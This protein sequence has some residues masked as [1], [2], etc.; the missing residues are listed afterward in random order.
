MADRP[1]LEARNLRTYFRT[2]EGIARAVDGVS[3]TLARGETLGLVGESGC[4][5]SVTALT[6]MQLVP[7]PA[8][9]LAGGEIVLDGDNLVLFTPRQKREM[10]GKRMAMVFQDPMTALNPVF[11]IGSQIVETIRQHRKATRHEARR[12]AIEML[13]RVGIPLPEQRFG[14]YS[15]QLSGGMQQRAMIA[16]ALCCQPDILIA[17]EPTTALDV[18]IQAQ[19]LDLLRALQKEFGM[20]IL[21]ITHNLGVVAEMAHRVSVMYA[22]KI[23]ES[24]PVDAL[25][26]QP[27]HPYTI[28]LF[29]SLPSR[30]WRGR[31][32]RAIPGIVPPATQFPSGCRFCTR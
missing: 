12:R 10:R 23:V 27:K 30:N 8:G 6:L 13:E 26:R 19:I 15:Y 32:L 21:L 3:F 25:F 14:E 5:K 24:A 9:Y 28:G 31:R 11:T 16:M 29:G 4:G 18:T 7:E 22:G 2:R 20:A 1:L 17:D